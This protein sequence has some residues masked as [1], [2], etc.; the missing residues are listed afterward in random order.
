MPFKG[1]AVL[2][3]ALLLLTGAI[4]AQ[5]EEPG[6]PLAQQ[7]GTSKQ[8]PGPASRLPHSPCAQTPPARASTFSLCFGH[9]VCVLVT[10]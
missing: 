7:R 5:W 3:S 1:R 10:L 8:E 2:S 6:P 9:G 4:W